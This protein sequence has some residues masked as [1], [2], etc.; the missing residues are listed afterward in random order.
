MTEKYE[1][2]EH[3]DKIPVVYT[4]ASAAF[5]FHH[6]CLEG[7]EKEDAD[8]VTNGICQ[9]HQDENTPVYNAGKVQRKNQCI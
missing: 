2:G 3:H 7:A 1:R 5:V 9:R 6:P 4:A 8:H